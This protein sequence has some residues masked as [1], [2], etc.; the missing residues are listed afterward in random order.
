MLRLALRLAGKSRATL[1]TPDLAE[2][3][4]LQG[5]RNG[6]KYLIANL[7]VSLYLLSTRLWM[8]KEIALTI[9]RKPPNKILGTNLFPRTIPWKFGVG[10]EEVWEQWWFRLTKERENND[11]FIIEPFFLHSFCLG[12]RRFANVCKL[13]LHNRMT[14]RSIQ[15][16]QEQRQKCW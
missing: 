13:V 3:F 4:P 8:A 16:H 10:R 6:W 15:L 9:N 12:C 2:A 14:R 1:Q 11:L 7:T 5:K